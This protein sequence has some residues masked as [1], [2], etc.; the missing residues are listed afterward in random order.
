LL[1]EASAQD[2]DSLL[3]WHRKCNLHRGLQKQR[4][5]NQRKYG[6]ERRF[7]MKTNR[8]RILAM[9]AIG[10]LAAGAY[11][12]PAQGIPAAEGKFTLSNEVRWQGTVLPAGDYSFSMES[13]SLPAE[14]LLRGPNGAQFVMPAGRSEDRSAQQSSL[15]IVC[16]GEWGYVREMYLAPLGVHFTFALPKVPKDQ[17]LAQG[18]ETTERVLISSAGK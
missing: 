10:L 6:L 17:L 16:R 12:A 11:A 14:I 9:A 5:T 15:T 2:A 13:A 8:I 1:P 18:P 3:L 4:A 7:T